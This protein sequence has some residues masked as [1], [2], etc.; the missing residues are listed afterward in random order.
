MLTQQQHWQLC[1]GPR[2]EDFENPDWERLYVSAGSRWQSR[3]LPQQEAK[4]PLDEVSSPIPGSSPWERVVCLSAPLAV[5][6]L[7][8]AHGI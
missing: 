1:L 7:R 4:V 6:A 2:H 8:S 5:A 3:G